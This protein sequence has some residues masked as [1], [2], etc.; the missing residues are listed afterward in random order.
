MEVNKMR[1]LLSPKKANLYVKLRKK[2]LSVKLAGDLINRPSLA[3]KVLSIRKR[4]R[5]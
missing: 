1:G 5:R 2:G 4:K 3:R